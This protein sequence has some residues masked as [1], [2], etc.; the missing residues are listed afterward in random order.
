MK[1]ICLVIAICLAGLMTACGGVG[2][3]GTTGSGSNSGGGG[4]GSNPG[5]GGTSADATCDTPSVIWGGNTNG[6]SSSGA[7]AFV[8]TGTMHQPR[9]AHTATLLA[10]GTVLVVDGGQLDIDDLLVSV[11]FAETFD[12]SQGKFSTT[13]TPCIA[14]ELHTATLLMNGKVLIAGGTRFSGYPTWLPATQTAELYDPASRS[15][16]MTGP[17]QSGRTEH[18]AT[19]LADGRVLIVGGSTSVEPMASAEIY[20]PDAGTFVAAASMASPRSNHTATMLSS[21]KVLIVGGE[22]D[23]AALASAE[24]YDPATNTFTSTGSM[25][26]PRSGHSANLLANGKVLIAGGVSSQIFAYG[27]LS[28]STDPLATAELYDP[29]TGT[30]SRAGPM[31]MGRV[32]HTATL[33]LNGKVL[34]A[35]GYIDWVN[36]VGYQNNSSAEIYDPAAGSFSSTDPMLATR[37]WHSATLLQDGSV[38]IAGGI[39]SDSPLASAEIYK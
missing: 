30:F 24:L 17:M 33:L 22:N 39:G 14:R 21:G 10:D 35:G 28:P 26:T 31:T 2:N 6:T 7:S 37:F 32:G 15:F 18:T 34:I 12:P 5:G 8:P 16:T 29:M 38:L 3:V 13:G 4:S 27:A 25:T 36:P 20:D 9:A 23:E 19:L 1:G 11:P